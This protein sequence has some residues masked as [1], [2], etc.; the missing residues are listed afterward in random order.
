M[1][2][3]G[4]KR[5]PHT[6]PSPH[7]ASGAGAQTRGEEDDQSAAAPVWKRE[8]GFAMS[9][10]PGVLAAP[11][12]VAMA[13][14]Q[15]E[16]D[17]IRRI[18]FFDGV[19]GLC[20]WSVDFVIKRDQR[21]EFQFAPLQGETAHAILKPADCNDLNSVVLVVGD[22]TYRKSAAVVRVLW[23]LSL[24]WQIVGTALWLIPL[25][26]RNL[27]YSLTASNRYRLFGKKDACRIPALEERARFLPLKR[28][29]KPAA[30]LGNFAP[31][32]HA[33]LEVM[34]YFERKLKDLVRPGM[35][36][37]PVPSA[38]NWVLTHPGSPRFLAV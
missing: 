32:R 6:H 31:A 29:N 34:R 4:R 28:N 14:D 10:V 21:G 3:A 2:A 5:V 19:C 12:D 33:S 36:L 16:T 13:I 11:A 7:K 9:T 26:L 37:A 27:G 20:N 30:Q 18:L 25:P 22:R 35:R 24:F 8:K 23:R 15:R 38:K 1:A 17:A